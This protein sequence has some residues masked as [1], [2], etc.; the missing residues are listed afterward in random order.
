MPLAIWEYTIFLLYNV[1]N[2]IINLIYRIKKN[3][4]MIQKRS[5]LVNK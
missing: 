4:N 1:P 5:T 3:I 2:I